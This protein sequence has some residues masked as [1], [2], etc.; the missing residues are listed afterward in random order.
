VPLAIKGRPCATLLPRNHVA[1]AQGKKGPFV[2]GVIEI[3]ANRFLSL[4]REGKM[5]EFE[6]ERK[7]RKSS[8][9]NFL[10]KNFFIPEIVGGKGKNG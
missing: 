7:E 2:V 1:L 8:S 5:A 4:F 10:T 6:Q 9:M 3:C